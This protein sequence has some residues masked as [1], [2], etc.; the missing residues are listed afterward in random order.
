MSMF[1]QGVMVFF[2]AYFTVLLLGFQSKLMRDNRWGMSF[3]TSWG[4]TLAQ[5]ATTWAIANNHLGMHLLILLSGTGGSIGIVSSH[6]LYQ[7]YDNW[8][9]TK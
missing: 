6:F 3:F 2:A 9:A 7:S 1:L 5:V 4:I 8:R